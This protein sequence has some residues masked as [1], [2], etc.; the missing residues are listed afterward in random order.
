MK[1][2]PT[3]LA[4]HVRLAQA[5]VITAAL[6]CGSDVFTQGRAERADSY[7][8]PYRTV[9]NPL[10]M[11]EGRELGWISGLGVDRNGK[12]IWVVDTCGGDLNGCVNS[13]VDPVMKF[14][15]SGKFVKSFGGGM[16][17]HPHALYVGPSGNIWIADGFGSQPLVEV[18]AYGKGQ[19]VLK[20][21]PD[22]ELLLT[23]GT[24]GVRGKTDSTFNMPSDVVV[25]PNGDIFVADGHVLRPDDPLTNQRIVKF[26][27]DGTFIKAWGTNGSGRG[28]FSETH[29]LTMD[30]QGRLFVADRRSNN[31]ILI[32]DQNGT[33]LD[34][35]R[36][37]GS[38]ATVDIDRQDVLYVA[39][40]LSGEGMRHGIYIGSAKDGRVTAFIPDTEP[41]QL[42]KYVVAD[43]SGNLWGG[44]A[45]GTMIRK[46]VKK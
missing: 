39:D 18:D 36:Q 34:E 7:P 24:P 20:F 45:S 31:R 44:Y 41:N 21:S 26:S 25:G 23:L 40:A 37:F 3:M 5:A 27:K 30:S 16:I 12:D 17:V 4:R 33:F 9:E 8:N 43:S 15:A 42:Q 22:G 10:T 29:S 13:T 38:P 46:Y 28:Q 35:W 11:P 14:D 19:Q 32:F 2:I 1:R 6:L